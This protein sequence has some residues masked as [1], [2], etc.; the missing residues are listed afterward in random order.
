MWQLIAQSHF[1]GLSKI[2]A[3]LVDLMLDEGIKYDH[4]KVSISSILF[5]DKTDTAL[6]QISDQILRCLPILRERPQRDHY[7][8]ILMSAGAQAF[9]QGA[10][11][12]L[13]LSHI[14]PSKLMNVSNSLRSY[15]MSLCMSS[16]VPKRKSLLYLNSASMFG[17]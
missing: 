17:I 15:I 12:V 9:A 6:T 14:Q 10:P 16:M 11:E 7:T 3:R 8:K 1:G 5:G 2:A 13:L 4:Y